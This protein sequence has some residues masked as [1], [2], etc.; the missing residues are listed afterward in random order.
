MRSTAPT[1][2]H[3]SVL[4]RR[5]RPSYHGVSFRYTPYAASNVHARR[6]SSTGFGLTAG[7]DISPTES[8]LTN[9]SRICDEL[10]AQAQRDRFHVPGT[11]RAAVENMAHLLEWAETIVW[12]LPTEDE[13]EDDGLVEFHAREV[14]AGKNL[15]LWLGD[16]ERWEMIVALEL[17]VPLGNAH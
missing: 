10:W 16:T 8:L 2:H 15:C 9:I 1:D 14:T 13:Y 17:E 4:C 3:A 11:E 7:S 6:E 5:R 12:N